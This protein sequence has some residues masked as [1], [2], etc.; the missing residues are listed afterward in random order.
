MKRRGIKC[1]LYSGKM[2]AKAALIVLFMLVSCETKPTK[3]IVK[4]TSAHVLPLRVH[5]KTIV[6]V[7]QKDSVEDDIA[8]ETATYY[9]VITDTGT[10]YYSLK[11]KMENIH[12]SLNI[13]IDTMVRYYNKTKDL[14][15]L[16][17]NDGDEI[18]AGD[19]FP[20]RTPSNFL[21]LEY[22]IFY[23]PPSS[24]NTIA[25]IAGIY[26]NKSSADSALNV[27]KPT[28]SNAFAIKASIYVG[29]MH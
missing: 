3:E 18:Y 2:K 21:S 6:P 13:P 8:D 9:V 28:E 22:M 27:L 11:A 7:R 25:L 19:Y 12:Q 16:P 5:T 14:I 15:A 26:E 1:G 23:Q 10:N 24:K 29:C 20:R 17:D 4:A